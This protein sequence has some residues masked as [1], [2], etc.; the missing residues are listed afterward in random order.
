MEKHSARGVAARGK[1]LREGCEQEEGVTLRENYGRLWTLFSWESSSSSI[2]SVSLFPSA[3]FLFSLV[4]R[5]LLSSLIHLDRAPSFLLSGILGKRATL[6]RHFLSGH[7]IHEIAK[8]WRFR[9]YGS[10]PGRE[11]PEQSAGQY[12]RAS[13][14]GFNAKF[15]RD[16][17]AKDYVVG[18]YRSRDGKF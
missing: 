6:R 14:T 10:G 12:A 11:R 4:E 8:R 5:T 1:R 18:V 7:C 13:F 15:M 9:F 17:V 2:N 3:L 16:P